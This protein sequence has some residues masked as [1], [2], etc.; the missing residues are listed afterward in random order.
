MGS[1]RRPSPRDLCFL[2]FSAL[3]VSVLARTFCVLPS[4]R[5]RHLPIVS[6][7]YCSLR[8]ATVRPSR[9]DTWQSD[10]QFSTLTPTDVV[11]IE[12]A[13]RKPDIVMS[14]LKVSCTVLKVKRLPPRYGRSNKVAHTTARHFYTYS[15]ICA[16]SCLVIVAS[17]IL[18]CRFLHFVFR[19]VWHPLVYYRHQCRW[20]TARRHMA[21]RVYPGL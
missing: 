1:I 7:R 18:A 19:V 4:G 20:C 3:V 11:A 15:P 10:L 9:S 8:V 16:P 12:P 14:H 6:C 17:T 13:Y 5:I 21:G 2:P